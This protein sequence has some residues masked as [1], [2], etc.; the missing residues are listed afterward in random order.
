MLRNVQYR[1]VHS[2]NRPPVRV[3]L[4]LA[5]FRLQPFT[6]FCAVLGQCPAL[7]SCRTESQEKQV[8][9]G[10]IHIVQKWSQIPLAI[11]SSVDRYVLIC[12]NML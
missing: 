5:L 7:V 6:K 11:R 10:N 9:Y 8:Q 1:N 4:F 2:D 12:S 3:V